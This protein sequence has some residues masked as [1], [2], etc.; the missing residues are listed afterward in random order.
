MP[1]KESSLMTVN[2][3]LTGALEIALNRYIALDPDA[4]LL[5]KP[6]TGKVIAIHFQPFHETL[7]LCPS[8][9]NMQI[10]DDYLGS[11]D[12]TLTGSPIAFGAKSFGSALPE[13]SIAIGGDCE[14]GQAFLDLFAKLNIDF[15]EIL[16]RYTGDIIAH[17]I[18]RFFRAGHHWMSDTL[19]TMRLNVTEFV[20]E[21]SRDLPARPETDIFYRKIDELQADLDGLQSRI[22]KLESSRDVAR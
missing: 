2:P 8:E 9:H 10:L 18:G 16:S 11:P 13:D 7:Y 14:V 6:L 12:A 3:F 4:S 22:E 5:L 1:H 20:Q 17:R 21:E 19:E 15:E